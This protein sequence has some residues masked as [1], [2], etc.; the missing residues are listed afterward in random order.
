VIATYGLTHVALNVR[1]LDRAFAFYRAVFGAVEVYRG[2]DFLQAQTPG[3][4]DV[5][6]FEL[7]SRPRGQAGGVKHLGFRLVRPSD[8]DAA[9]EAV[10]AAGGQILEQGEFVPGEPYLFA[11]DPDGYVLEIW[12]EIPTPVDPPTSRPKAIRRPRTT[13]RRM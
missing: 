4:R 9:A 5:L 10:R 11:K 12:F 6:V 3:T 7:A 13:R 2:A 8:I 1:D